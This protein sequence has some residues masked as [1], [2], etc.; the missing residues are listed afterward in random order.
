[1]V[2]QA[3]AAKNEEEEEQPANVCNKWEGRRRGAKEEY[4]KGSTKH[5]SVKL[6]GEDLRARLPVLF[7]GTKYG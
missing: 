2:H 7:E 4:M 3:R 6:L 1:M 5:T